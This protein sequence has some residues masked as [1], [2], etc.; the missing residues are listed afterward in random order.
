M[1]RELG[2]KL[3]RNVAPAI[4]ATKVPVYYQY[5][6]KWYYLDANGKK[7]EVSE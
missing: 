1:A 5:L 7:E 4:D 3:P 6:S 2:Y